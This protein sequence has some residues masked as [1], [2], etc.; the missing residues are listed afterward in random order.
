M[1]DKTKESL[2]S[3]RALEAKCRE[4]IGVIAESQKEIQVKATNAAIKLQTEQFNASR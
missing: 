3:G 1:N 2:N 4:V